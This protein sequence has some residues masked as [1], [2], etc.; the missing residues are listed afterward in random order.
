M[1]HNYTGPASY[2]ELAPANKKRLLPKKE[3]NH[4]NENQAHS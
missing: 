3:E 4:E 2:A 1:V